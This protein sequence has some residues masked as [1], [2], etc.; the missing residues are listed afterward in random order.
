MEGEEDDEEDEYRDSGGNGD[1][2]SR[3][4]R[5]EE[6]SHKHTVVDELHA[7]CRCHYHLLLFVDFMP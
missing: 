5:I 7:L 3:K 1:D 6:E 4:T 2:N